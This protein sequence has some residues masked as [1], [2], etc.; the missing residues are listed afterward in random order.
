M[1]SSFFVFFFERKDEK[2]GSQPVLSNFIRIKF[3]KTGWKPA[4]LSFFLEKKRRKRWFPPA[5]PNFI[6]IYRIKFDNK[7]TG[8]FTAFSPFFP[9]KV[10][11]RGKSESWLQRFPGFNVSQGLSLENRYN[12]VLLYF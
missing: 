2:G 4:F 9:Y 7:L 11:K 8:W 6:Q 3:N 10:K 12:E 1:K 5:L